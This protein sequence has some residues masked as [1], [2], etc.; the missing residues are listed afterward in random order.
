VTA[1]SDSVPSLLLLPTCI[2]H[3]R[4]YSSYLVTAIAN[5]DDDG[6]SDGD[7]DAIDDSGNLQC[8]SKK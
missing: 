5:D 7:N 6:G 2:G 8:E 4:Y 3:Q 1:T